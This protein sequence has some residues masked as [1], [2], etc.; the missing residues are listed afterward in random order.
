MALYKNAM[1]PVFKSLHFTR[2]V[3][4][5]YDPSCPILITIS[6]F[7]DSTRAFEQRDKDRKYDISQSQQLF[8]FLKIRAAAKKVNKI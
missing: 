1:V 3:M 2:N 4:S 5:Y 6:I 8:P 7:A